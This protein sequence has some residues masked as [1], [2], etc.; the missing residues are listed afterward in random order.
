MQ[1]KIWQLCSVCTKS[2]TNLVRVSTSSL[3]ARDSSLVYANI[4]N[5][6]SHEEMRCGKFPLKSIMKLDLNL[7]VSN[8]ETRIWPPLLFPMLNKSLVR[9]SH[10]SNRNNSIS[11][12]QI[13]YSFHPQYFNEYDVVCMINSTYFTMHTTTTKTTKN[14]FSL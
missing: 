11:Y 8:L 14:I 4:S 7:L 5:R 9:M 13:S 3:F 10:T 1:I 2:S 6:T 12:G